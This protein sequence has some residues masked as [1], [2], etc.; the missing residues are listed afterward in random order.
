MNKTAFCRA[1]W[2]QHIQ[3]NSR[4]WVETQLQLSVCFC[5][6]FSKPWS[7]D[8]LLY[9]LPYLK[10]KNSTWRG[11]GYSSLWK[12]PKKLQSSSGQEVKR[13]GS[14]VELFPIK[15]ARELGRWNVIIYTGVW[16]G[17]SALLRKKKK[18]SLWSLMNRG[19]SKFNISS[20]KK[21]GI[22]FLS[23]FPEHKCP[24]F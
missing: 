20:K 13:M 1:H 6:V 24:S 11:G 8:P 19:R 14:K 4:K 9:D 16:P 21:N 3:H 10:S 23:L 17:F 18:S 15:A 2:I 22:R 5:C 12:M 7:T